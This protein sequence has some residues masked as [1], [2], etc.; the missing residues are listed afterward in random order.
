MH[1]LVIN[2]SELEQHYVKRKNKLI[3]DQAISEIIY[4]TNITYHSI[5][6]FEKLN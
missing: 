3:F 1:D 2:I 6:I 4:S 5:N